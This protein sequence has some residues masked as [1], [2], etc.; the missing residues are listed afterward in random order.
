MAESGVDGV[1]KGLAI[2]ALAL[3]IFGAVAPVVGLYIG[4][5]ALL[6]ACGAAL[7][8]DR[9]FTIATVIISLV[10]FAFLTPSLWITEGLAQIGN[11]A[12]RSQGAPTIMNPFVVVSLVLLV[13]PL[14]CIFLNSSGRVVLG[15]GSVAR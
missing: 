4:W 15:R 7:F 1:G 6:L 11:A 5:I 13:A 8:G 9:G 2:G 3:S 14:L 12:A 10:A